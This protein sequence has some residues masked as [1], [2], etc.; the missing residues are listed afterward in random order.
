MVHIYQCRYNE[1]LAVGDLRIEA[2][3]DLNFSDSPALFDHMLQHRHDN[4]E[5]LI[6]HFLA[7]VHQDEVRKITKFEVITICHWLECTG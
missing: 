5:L 7:I 6:I 3:N 2:T 1:Y 4:Y